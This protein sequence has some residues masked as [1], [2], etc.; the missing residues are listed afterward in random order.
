MARAGSG[1]VTEGMVLAQRAKIGRYNFLIY[2]GGEGGCGREYR[3]Y[4]KQGSEMRML[5]R[6]ACGFASE[7]AA[8]IDEVA[9]FVCASCPGSRPAKVRAAI[10]D[11]IRYT[12]Y[13][14][15]PRSSLT[16]RNSQAAV[17]ELQ[18]LVPTDMAKGSAEELMAHL[19]DR[20][21]VAVVDVHYDADPSAPY[22]V[23]EWRDG[24]RERFDLDFVD[25]MFAPCDASGRPLAKPKAPRAAAG[26]AA[27]ILERGASTA[28]SPA[29]AAKRR[30]KNGR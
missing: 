14:F 19:Y 16:V 3:L 9:D 30:G 11:E 18:K 6:W 1:S 8:L 5:L 20:T 28:Q 25:S 27:K 13:R 24:F 26:R 29:V 15:P 22:Y 7:K 4:A 2:R 17:R 12:C 21:P 23:L 10:G